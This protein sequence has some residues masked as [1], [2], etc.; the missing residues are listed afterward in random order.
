MAPIHDATL[1]S[2]WDTLLYAVPIFLMM[3]AGFF[4]LDEL[5][6]SQKSS[7]KKRRS[8][9]GLDQNGQPMLCDPDG[10]PFNPR[11]EQK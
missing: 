4:R 6:V 1:Q 2:G 9:S 8:F 5:F 7:P 11:G 10:R 3:F